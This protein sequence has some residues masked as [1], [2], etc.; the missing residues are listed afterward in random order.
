MRQE[1]WLIKNDENDDNDDDNDDDD[2]DPHP[3]DCKMELN[4]GPFIHEIHV[5]QPFFL[6]SS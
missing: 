1:R 4:K 3:H 2:D 5:W 6:A